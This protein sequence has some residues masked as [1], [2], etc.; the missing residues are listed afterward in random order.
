MNISSTDTVIAV[1][2]DDEVN[3][4]S[5][6]LAKKFGCKKAISLVNS[7]SF[8]PLFS[9]LGIDIIVNPRE[10]TV[11]SISEYI[12]EFKV[13]NAHAI[14]DLEVEIIE[15][16]VLESSYSVGKTISELKL[17]D[18]IYICMLV[19]NGKIIIPDDNFEI[20][21]RDRLIILSRVHEV[22]KV[23]RLFSDKFK[24]F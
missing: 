4:L 1:S 6:L 14:C 24:Y 19:R 16:D 2:N 21:A 7:V 15:A 3:I 10:I 11:S 20:M 8:A 9:S 23:E 17:P 13:R 22:K 18:A 5:A 12:R